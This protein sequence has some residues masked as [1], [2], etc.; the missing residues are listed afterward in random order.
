MAQ[1]HKRKI[2]YFQWNSLK[3]IEPKENIKRSGIMA[4]VGVKCKT[5]SEGV[6]SP[7]GSILTAWWNGKFVWKD[8]DTKA[9]EERW[10]Q[11]YK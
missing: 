11:Y 2:S 8:I 9:I 10:D 4:P 6:W 5:Q 1:S 3:V 7:G